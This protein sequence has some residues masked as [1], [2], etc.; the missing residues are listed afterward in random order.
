M[1][2]DLGAWDDTLNGNSV[3]RP[4]SA[5]FV[6]LGVFRKRNRG[7]PGQDAKN[8]QK[9]PFLRLPGYSVLVASFSR[10][11]SGRKTKWDR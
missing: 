8:E 6:A 2:G 7:C 4:K 9:W 10:D 3:A 11:G 1:R 5:C